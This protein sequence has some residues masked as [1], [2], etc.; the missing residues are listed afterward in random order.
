MAIS[1]KPLIGT[2]A[3]VTAGT[4]SA[5]TTDVYDNTH[6]VVVYN[7]SGTADVYVAF[8]DDASIPAATAVK[9]PPTSSMTLPIGTISQRPASGS[10]KF[11]CSAGTVNNIA[12][13]YLNGLSS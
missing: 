7:P 8:T 3:S 10:L 2:V 9:I 6:T 12:I 5:P 13:T 4:A 11:D 1:N